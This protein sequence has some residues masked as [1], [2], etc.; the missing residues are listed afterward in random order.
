MRAFALALLTPCALAAVVSAA[1]PTLVIERGGIARHAVVAVGRDLVIDGEA[2]ADVAALNGSV[3]ISGS[4]AGDVLVMGGGARLEPSARVSG[5]VFVLGGALAAAPG[6]VIGGRA[7]SYPTVS[8]AWL[9]LLEGPVLG[10]SALSPLVLGAKLALLAAWAA[11]LLLFFAASGREV[12]STSD[13]VQREPLRAFLVGVTGVF[14]LVLTALFFVALAAA[15]VGLP[16]LV[17]VVIL[18]LVLKLWGMVAVFHAL[19]HWLC[20]RFARR[21]VLPVTAACVGLLALGAVKLVPWA[22]TMAWTAATFLGV[23]ATLITKFGRRE[24]WFLANG[25]VLPSP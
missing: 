14:A 18:A 16:L 3:R 10:A 22:G 17:L 9:T 6:A 23:G 11:L 24:P 4:V 25:V 5:D 8:A 15:L 19:G 20:R 21:G 12:L 13:A 1:E 2:L 7:V